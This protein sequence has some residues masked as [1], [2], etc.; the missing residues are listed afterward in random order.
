MQQY[1]HDSGQVFSRLVIMKK[2]LLNLSNCFVLMK[3]GGLSSSS[4]KLSSHDFWQ[5]T[6]SVLNKGKSVIPPI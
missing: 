5:I 4:Q 1:Q 2:E 3:E 6:N